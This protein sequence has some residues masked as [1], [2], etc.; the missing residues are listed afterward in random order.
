MIVD[1]SIRKDRGSGRIIRRILNM[2]RTLRLRIRVTWWYSWWMEYQKARNCK[3]LQN[4]YEV[5]INMIKVLFI[6]HGN[7]MIA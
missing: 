2:Q 3:F 7:K 4:K 6:C 5:K 1:R